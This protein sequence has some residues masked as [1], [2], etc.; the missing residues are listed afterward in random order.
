MKSAVECPAQNKAGPLFITSK[1]TPHRRADDE[2]VGESCCEADAGREDSCGGMA[3]AIGERETE[4]GCK[5]AAHVHEIDPCLP[6]HSCTK[7]VRGEIDAGSFA[8]VCCLRF[9]KILEGETS[10]WGW[11]D[12]AS[13]DGWM[14]GWMDG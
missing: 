11:R 12:G 5:R 9:G 10:H 14:D 1:C 6:H 4:R 7:N 8:G 3:G 2:L 13:M